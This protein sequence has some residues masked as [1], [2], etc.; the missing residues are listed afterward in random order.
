VSD[1]ED[2][3]AGQLRMIDGPA[4]VREHR[5]HPTRKWRFDFAWPALLLAVEVEGGS[6]TGGA[7]NRG[8][9]FESDAVKYS[10]AAVLGWRI[11]RVTTDMVDDGRA[12][13]LICRALHLDAEVV[14]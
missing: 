7:H 13:G 2:R 9:H 6:W 4:Y 8:A 14:G 12:V 10:E 11:I 5:F 1:L 3:L